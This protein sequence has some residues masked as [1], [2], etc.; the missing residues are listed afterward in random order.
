[1]GYGIG[2]HTKP[3]TGYS[4][5]WETPPKI[6]RALG[7][8]DDDPRLPGK[9]DGLT[10][11]WQ[12]LVWLNPPYTRC[13]LGAWLEKLSLHPMGGIALIFARTETRL[14][15]EYVW[16]R[17][18]ALLFLYGRPHFYQNGIRAAGNS[19]GPVVLVGYGE[20]ATTRLR[21]CGLAGAYVSGWL[22][23]PLRGLETHDLEPCHTRI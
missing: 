2:G 6:L 19:G 22:S 7:P 13:G 18:S 5:E 9:H 10:R 1:M 20:Q 23:E 15:V 8:F 11:A 4:T 17:A 14:F 3:N 21:T 16:N 12:G